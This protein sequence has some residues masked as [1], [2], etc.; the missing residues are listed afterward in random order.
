MSK[1][2]H[3]GGRCVCFLFFDAKER[4]FVAKN[5]SCR[6]LE[7]IGVFTVVRFRSAKLSMMMMMMMIR[8]IE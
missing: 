8:T 5:V 4:I 1:K 6:P 7:E 3:G 2:H